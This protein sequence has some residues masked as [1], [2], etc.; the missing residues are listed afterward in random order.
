MMV[1]QAERRREPNALAEPELQWV[2]DDVLNILDHDTVP[3]YAI[4]AHDA[5]FGLHHRCRPQL[6]GQVYLFCHHLIVMIVMYP[7]MNHF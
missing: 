3:Q 6:M 5:Y 1:V 7:Q 2:T 4:M